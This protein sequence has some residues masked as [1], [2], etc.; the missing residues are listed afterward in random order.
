MAGNEITFTLEDVRRTL[1]LESGPSVSK[2]STCLR[3]LNSQPTTELPVSIDSFFFSFLP[4]L[5]SGAVIH[6]LFI[7]SVALNDVND[8]LRTVRESIWTLSNTIRHPAPR[9]LGRVN[10]LSSAADT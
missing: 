4:L 2:H 10:S 3:R 9:L 7:S 6:L 8:L 5:P 1:Q